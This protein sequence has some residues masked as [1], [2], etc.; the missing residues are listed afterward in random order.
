MQAC[1]A[2]TH[3]DDP[4]E[5][6]EVEPDRIV[7]DPVE[8]LARQSERGSYF[9][10]A[11]PASQFLDAAGYGSNECKLLVRHQR[12]GEPALYDVRWLRR[13]LHQSL[14]QRLEGGRDL[15]KR[16]AQVGQF[17]QGQTEQTSRPA[18][19]K[20]QAQQM[21]RPG[22]FDD[23]SLG[24]GADPKRR[25]APRRQIQDQIRATIRKHADGGVH[26]AFAP[27]GPDAFEEG[28]ELPMGRNFV[29]HGRERIAPLDV[30]RI[31]D[32]EEP[33]RQ[34][35]PARGGGKPAAAIAA[36]RTPLDGPLMRVSSKERL[37]AGTTR[38]SLL[39]P[40]KWQPPKVV[41]GWNSPYMS[42]ERPLS[43]V[44]APSQ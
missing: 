24:H 1:G 20:P 32:S 30:A 21:A 2:G 19:M 41:I 26:A 23:D 31:L 6:L 44:R 4:T 13:R 17:A 18:R 11:C 40:V 9:T 34:R 15:P 38:R 12:P 28:L 43:A 10:D 7:H 39:P 8:I 35:S 14:Q 22:A 37:G 25:L 29:V 16:S 5:R 3:A 27:V 36:R 42:E 33:A